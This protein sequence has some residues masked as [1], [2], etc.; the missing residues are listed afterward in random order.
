MYFSPV[1]SWRLPLSDAPAPFGTVICFS[2]FTFFERRSTGFTWQTFTLSP[3][4]QPSVWLLCCLCPPLRKLAFSLPLLVTRSRSS[5]VPTSTVKESR[6][7]PLHA[8][9]IGGDHA[10]NELC[11]PSSHLLV[12][13]SHPVFRLLVLTTPTRGFPCLPEGSRCQH[14][15]QGSGRPPSRVGVKPFF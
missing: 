1:G 6:S 14:R 10:T 13:A 15:T 4:L 8:G 3:S 9:G 12:Q 11:M 5:Q 7:C 2:Q